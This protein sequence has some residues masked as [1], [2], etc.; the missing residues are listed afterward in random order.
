M[1]S[2]WRELA[3]QWLGGDAS[4]ALT[5]DSPFLDRFP[6]APATEVPAIIVT[7]ADGVSHQALLRETADPLLPVLA[8]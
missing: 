4:E 2:I 1:R 7:R 6:L 3:L 8:N 5:A